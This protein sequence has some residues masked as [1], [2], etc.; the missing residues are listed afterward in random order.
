MLSIRSKK[1]LCDLIVG[2]AEGER[3]LE[4]CRQVLCELRA[5]EPYTSFVRLDR[6]G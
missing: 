2:I 4:I 3:R 5:F 1:Q 6:K